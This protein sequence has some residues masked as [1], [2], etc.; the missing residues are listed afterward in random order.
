MQP[1][2][3]RSGILELNTTGI[4]ACL[5]NINQTN[6]S[7]LTCAPRSADWG[8]SEALVI[9]IDSH[10]AFSKFITTRDL[11]FSTASCRSSTSTNLSA[12]NIL[13]QYEDGD[14]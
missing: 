1:S 14:H 12:L 2:S 4:N 3:E 6:I 9:T 8:P 13:L 10:K 7:L 11:R 5:H